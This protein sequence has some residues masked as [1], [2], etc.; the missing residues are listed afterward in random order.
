MGARLFID[1]D[2]SYQDWLQGHPNGFVVNTSKNPSPEY[3][4][5]H[6]ATCARIT[7]YHYAGTGGL[8]GY[9]FCFDS[10]GP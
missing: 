2:R 9:P 10:F 1:D 6:R 7:R 4:I 5:L 8:V 3:M